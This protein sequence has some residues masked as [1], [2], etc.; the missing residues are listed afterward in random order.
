MSRHQYI[1]DLDYE[2]ALNEFEGYE[3]EEENELSPEDRALMNQGTADV[4]AALGVEAFKVTVA[5]IEDSL[6]HYYYD[7]DKTVAYLISKY[8]NAS[9]KATK[10][11]APPPP[12]G[13]SVPFTMYTA[14]ATLPPELGIPAYWAAKGLDLTEGGF[15]AAQP[16]PT[17]SAA[18]CHGPE[19]SSTPRDSLTP[20]TVSFKSRVSLAYL[21]RDMP[22]GNIPMHRQTTFIP[23][24][25][26]R[27]GL[28]GGSGAPP[29]MSKL[30]ALAAARKKKAEEKKAIDD[31]VER[32]RAKVEGLAVE[33]P[34][35]GK[36]NVPLTG[37]SSKRL[38]TSES[39]AQG[40]T[41]PAFG[42]R[43]TQQADA[44][45]EGAD[46]PSTHDQGAVGSQS[47]AVK[48]KAEEEEEEPDVFA[49]P[50]A[51]A[52]L[53]C[54][55]PPAAPKPKAPSYDP[56]AGFGFGYGADNKGSPPKK[57][58]TSTD[59]FDIRKRKRDDSDDYEE[60]VILYPNLPQSV[61]DVF[62]QPS[63]DDIVLAAQAKAKTKGS[64]LKKSQR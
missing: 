57:P 45:V 47:D 16:F 13:K 39:T 8:V 50:S 17:S 14:A 34:P 7:I 10:S 52:Q 28:L 42:P 3:E 60:V 24:R 55:N 20:A 25:M 5:Q 54:G 35:T 27:G 36:E 38:K 64:L 15:P 18:P 12:N 41:V 29:K 23:P 62:A 4:Q 31:K 63:P 32:T 2:E 22:W 46:D 21:F 33:D 49:K 30:Q 19:H 61:R 51:F 53:L 48:P 26:P 43:P 37:P 6:W 59:W 56:F 40:R 44:A 9:P 58:S 11:A 1:R